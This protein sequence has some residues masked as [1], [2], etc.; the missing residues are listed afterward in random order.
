MINYFLITALLV[1]PFMAI[2]FIPFTD[3]VQ[4]ILMAA[5]VSGAFGVWCGVLL[6]AQ[7][8]NRMIR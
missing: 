3:W 6:L 2:G 4:F 1:L 5:A 7:I 8:R